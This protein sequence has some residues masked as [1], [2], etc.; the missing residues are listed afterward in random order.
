M[1]FSECKEFQKEFKKLLKKYNSLESDFEVFKIALEDDPIWAEL[2]R[3]HIVQI[4]GLWKDISWDFY[5][6]RRFFCK[7][8]RWNWDLR[9]IYK[10]SYEERSIEFVEIEFIEIFHKNQKGNHDRERIRK[11]YKK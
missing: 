11:Y 7:S 3:D 5:K 9:L 8:L 2:P 6:V 10:Y 4:S 1:I